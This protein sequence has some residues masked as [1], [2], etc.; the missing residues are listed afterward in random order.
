MMEPGYWFH[1][2]HNKE[3]INFLIVYNRKS[4]KL[5]RPT[6]P[7]WHCSEGHNEEIIIFSRV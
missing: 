2:S 5:R 6:V 7:W 4:V 1:K 3:I